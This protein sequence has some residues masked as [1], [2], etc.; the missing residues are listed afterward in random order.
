MK[1]LFVLF[2]SFSIFI[3]CQSSLSPDVLPV[4]GPPEI[5]P[6]GD[7]IPHRIPDFSFID[8]D[9]QVVNNETFEGKAYVT[10]F[11]FIACPTICPKT[12]KQMLRINDRFKD[13]PNL[14]LLGHTLAPKY[15]TVAALNRYAKNLGVSSDKYHFVTGNQ[16]AIYKMAPEYMNVALE[17]S[18][19]PGG[20]N[21]SGY[22]I[23]VDKK[24]HIR[25]FCNGT[26][27]EDVDRFMNDIEKLLHEE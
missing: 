3:G 10:D 9:S 7:S 15:D 20:I 25:S 5:G 16:A 2:A 24:R 19:A 6:N 22:L 27:P 8:Q 23:L 14:L 18:D 1:Y 4:L 11:F 12:A 21:H 17:D 26:D 13:E